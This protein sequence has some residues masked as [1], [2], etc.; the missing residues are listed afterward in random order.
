MSGERLMH[1]V[2]VDNSKS[3][4]QTTDN[5]KSSQRGIYAVDYVAS[6]YGSASID[7]LVNGQYYSVLSMTEQAHQIITIPPNTIFRVSITGGTAPAV[8]LTELEWH[9]A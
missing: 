3:Y 5:L 2:S 8:R 4:T 1:T 6:S 7:F 9:T